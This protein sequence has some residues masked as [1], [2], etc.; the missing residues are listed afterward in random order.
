MGNRANIPE[1]ALFFF[2]FFLSDCVLSWSIISVKGN[3]K[4]RQNFSSSTLS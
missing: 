3:M 2:L 1:L 4:W